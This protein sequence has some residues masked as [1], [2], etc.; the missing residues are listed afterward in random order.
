MSGP[1]GNTAEPREMGETRQPQE[2][3][4]MEKTRQPEGETTMKDVTERQVGFHDQSNCRLTL[5]VRSVQTQRLYY[6]L[7]ASLLQAIFSQDV[8]LSKLT[9][10]DVRLPGAPST[11]HMSELSGCMCVLHSPLFALSF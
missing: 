11:L 9:G 1:E 8:N 10:C 3:R 7:L 5:D 4:E 6:L 2:T